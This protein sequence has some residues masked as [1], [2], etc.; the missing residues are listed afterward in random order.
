MKRVEIP[1]QVAFQTLK[2]LALSCSNVLAWPQAHPLWAF[3][4]YSGILGDQPHCKQMPMACAQEASCP[5]HTRPQLPT[6]IEVM[7]SSVVENEVQV[8]LPLLALFHS[9]HLLFSSLPTAHHVTR[10]RVAATS[11]SS[12][13]R[14]DGERH[15]GTASFPLCPSLGIRFLPGSSEAEKSVWDPFILPFSPS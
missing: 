6:M 13:G 9:S 12:V 4:L 5:H 2:V 1:Q 15:L 7:Q 14:D 3:L 10:A 11:F 8:T